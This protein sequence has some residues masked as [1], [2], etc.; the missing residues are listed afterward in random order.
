MYRKSANPRLSKFQPD[1]KRLETA[2]SSGPRLDAAIW[3]PRSATEIAA[4]EADPEVIFVT[5]GSGGGFRRRSA[6]P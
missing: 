5:T 1:G 2:Y 6:G 4:L 3:A